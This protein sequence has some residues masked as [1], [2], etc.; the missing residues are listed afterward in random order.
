MRPTRQINSLS[1]SDGERDG[2]RGI[3][4]ILKATWNYEATSTGSRR[5][6]QRFLL[7]VLFGKEQVK[8]FHFGTAF[9]R[10]SEL[11]AEFSVLVFWIRN[12]F[13][14][15]AVHDPIHVFERDLAD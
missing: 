13:L 12:Q 14:I 2:V 9:Q 8:P 10:S 5:V 3:R 15:P 4:F 1:P 7:P 6:S 11:V